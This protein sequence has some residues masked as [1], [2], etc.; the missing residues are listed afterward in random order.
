MLTRR[1]FI[2]GLFATYAASTTLSA[3]KVFPLQSAEAA[4]EDTIGQVCWTL[5]G[6]GQHL[7]LHGRM[8]GYEISSRRTLVGGDRVYA[9][10]DMIEIENTLRA[11]VVE[12]Y[13]ADAALPINR[14]TAAERERIARE[15]NT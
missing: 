1:R 10:R 5:Y 6:T 12:K 8:V 4:V 11:K 15:S 14:T 9:E 3:S 7:Y 13:G 2:Q